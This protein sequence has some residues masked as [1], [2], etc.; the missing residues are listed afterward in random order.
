MLLSVPWRKTHDPA[1]SW[2][3]EELVLWCGSTKLCTVIQSEQ[4]PATVL[5]AGNKTH[6]VQ[7][8]SLRKFVNESNK[9]GSELLLFLIVPKTLHPKQPLLP[10]IPSYKT[11]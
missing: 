1:I 2:A 8:V 4:R 3:R 9:K 6:R 10:L 11:C 7:T 5:Q